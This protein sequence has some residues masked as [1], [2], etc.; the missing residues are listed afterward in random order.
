M[1]ETGA[2]LEEIGRRFGVTRERVRQILK[3]TDAPSVAELGARRRAESRGAEDEVTRCAEQDLMEHPATTIEE[4][5]LRLGLWSSR[6]G[7]LSLLISNQGFGSD[8]PHG[9]R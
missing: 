5:A 2:T 8:R 3:D 1:R 4:T 7:H 6:S 9:P